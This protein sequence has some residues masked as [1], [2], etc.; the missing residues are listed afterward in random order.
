MVQPGVSW[1]N[2]QLHFNPAYTTVSLAM[3][4][5]DNEFIACISCQE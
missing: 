4:H 2:I 5:E 1:K 3:E